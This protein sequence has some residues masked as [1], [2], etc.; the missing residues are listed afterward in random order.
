MTH[1]HVIHVMKTGKVGMIEAIQ[2][3]HQSTK[4]LLR[5]EV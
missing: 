4:C 1:R 3:L 5:R 2:R